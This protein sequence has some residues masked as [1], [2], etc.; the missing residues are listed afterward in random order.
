L[1][2]HGGKSVCPASC[3]AFLPFCERITIL[4]AGDE[5]EPTAKGIAM[6]MHLPKPIE[7]FMSSD[8]HDADAL[9][10]CFASDATVRD[11]GRTR[12]GLAD[13]AAW[14]RETT[15]KYHHSVE[16]VAVAE[17][18]G[19]IIVA[20]KVSGDFPGSPITLDFVF[21]LE[22]GKISSLEIRS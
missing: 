8:A 12:E 7:R 18:D 4:F 19:K 15:D 5:R 14:R 22:H 9:A 21:Q 16:P 6:S 17:R 10:E 11:E 2:C 3:L 20:T 13:I 1:I